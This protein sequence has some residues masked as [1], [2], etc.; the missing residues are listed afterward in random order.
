MWWRISNKLTC[1]GK[2][3]L[4]DFRWTHD[5][6]AQYYEGIRNVSLHFQGSIG[7]KIINKSLNNTH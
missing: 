5:P 7:K 4:S 3:K 1:A 2:A 6:R